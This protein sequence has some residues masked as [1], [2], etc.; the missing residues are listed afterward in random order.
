MSV[1]AG[2]KVRGRSSGRSVKEICENIEFDSPVEGVK[3]FADIL[4]KVVAYAYLQHHPVNQMLQSMNIDLITVLTSGKGME[5]TLEY[6]A[7]V[8]A[9]AGVKLGWCD[10][11]GYHM[12]GGE[13]GAKALVEAAGTVYAGVKKDHSV[14]IQV[15]A[16]GFLCV[17]VIPL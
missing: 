12:V 9:T 2:G 14:K 6:S 3:R 16:V 11:E 7:S 10:T 8:G 13:I 1:S 17:I 15:G 5:A 4:L